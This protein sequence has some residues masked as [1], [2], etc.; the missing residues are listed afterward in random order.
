VRCPTALQ[1]AAVRSSSC[2]A[3]GRR[4]SLAT[5]V[6][7]LSSGLLAIL[8]T[9]LTCAA[10]ADTS[11]GNWSI[12]PREAWVQSPPAAAAQAS[13]ATGV[14][15]HDRQIRITGDGD[16]RYE[17]TVLRVSGARLV[18]D[19][20][21]ID[22]PVNPRFQQL[23][24][25]A[26]RLTHAGGPARV[27]TPAQI[28]EQLLI[29]PREAEPRKRELN[30]QLRISI[31]VPD[32]H[33]GD[34]L[35]F[36]Y[37]VQSHAAGMPG[38]FAGHYAAQWSSGGD[39]P[40]R[41]ERLHVSWPAGRALRYRLLA[42]PQSS[43][44][45]IQTHPG[46]LDL[47]W[48][49][50]APPAS[51]PD[52][53]RWFEH[54]SA[55]Q[56]SDFA[57]WSQVAAFLA[58]Q[59]GRPVRDQDRQPEALDPPTSQTAP[60]LILN[61]LRL[62]QAKVQATNVPGDGPYVPADPAI[63]LQ[64]GYGDSRDLARLLVSL[65]HRAAI[66]AQVALANSRGV[67]LDDTLPSPFML[68]TAVV[69]ARAGGIDY[70]LNPAAPGPAVALG[71]TDPA[72]LRRALLISA[73]GG[74]L[75]VLPRPAPD[76]RLHAVS[77][78]F[79]LRNGNTQPATLTLT[80]QFR[81]SWAQA[82]R[83]Q[84]LAQSPAQ[85]QLTQMQSVAQDYPNATAD[86]EVQLQDLPDRQI[87]QLRARFRIPRP[88]GANGD[89]QFNFFAEALAAS[90]Q[91][92]D[93]ATRRYPLDLPW[94]LQLEEH[95]SA[96]LPPGFIAPEGR[97]VIATAAFR[98]VRNVRFEHGTLHIDH[99]YVALADH[100]AAADYPQLLQANAQVYQALGVHVQAQ[101]FSWHDMLRRAYNWIFDKGEQ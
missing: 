91:P 44:P 13:P 78:Q 46:E 98:Y 63:V 93:E 94:P 41:W 60:G 101:G 28:R 47:Q 84:L 72:D 77:Q 73:T 64:R 5:T 11:S 3:G 51:E 66:D 26:L 48:R 90:V 85:L 79:D 22:V 89:P 62:V 19:S 50:F 7:R 25:H 70:W 36:E 49:N 43:A 35:E 56:L 32:V 18:D 59:Y 27:F 9:P 71:T 31:Q 69:V 1:H 81:G 23:V 15:L 10:S 52:T 68:D 54:T 33:A 42:A 96:A 97:I 14:L 40:V 74:K 95:I 16:E 61:A 76:S 34:L 88:L 29:Q 75:V 65:L 53:P 20:T 39:E 86:G 55:V 17:H 92:R 4:I 2:Y 37:T 83:A 57:D 82:V 24:I 67:L 12:A 30:P 6:M 87:V 8:V 100:V 80:T 38:A 45:Q 99:S 58:P 21:Q